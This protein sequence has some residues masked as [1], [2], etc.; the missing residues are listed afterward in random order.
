MSP[1]RMEEWKWTHSPEG[2]SQM[3][4]FFKLDYSLP[5][6]IL[7]LSDLVEL[8]LNHGKK[9]FGAAGR[10]IVSI[11]V[12]NVLRELIHNISFIDSQSPPS[13]T[14]HLKKFIADLFNV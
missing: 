13:D 9:E 2:K 4:R 12:K 1:W 6:M 14:G 10:S 3:I 7:M 5:S 11:E 8:V